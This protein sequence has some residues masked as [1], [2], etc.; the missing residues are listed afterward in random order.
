MGD[1]NLIPAARMDRRRRKARIRL[2]IAICGTYVILLVGVALWSCAFRRDT[3]DWVIEQLALTE[4]RIGEYNATI[5]EFRQQLA[6]A[7]R[8]LEASKSISSQPDWTKLLILVGDELGDQIVLSVCQIATLSKD[9]ENVTRSLQESLSPAPPGV[10]AAEQYRLE[11][12]GF[13]RTQTS[14]S[15]F[16]LRLEQMQIF[17]KVELANSRRQDFLSDKAVAFNIKCSI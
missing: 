2:W 12:S 5:S 6:E 3:G 9:G 10:H 14:V 11:L 1:V 16:A 17:D 15:Q 7:Q 13:G 8:E 4:Q